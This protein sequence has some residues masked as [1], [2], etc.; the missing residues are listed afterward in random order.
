MSAV[1]RAIVLGAAAAILLAVLLEQAHALFFFLAAGLC[2][3]GDLL[4]RKMFRC[5]LDDSAICAA[6]PIDRTFDVT[7]TGN[8][9]RFFDYADY[10]MSFSYM[11]FYTSEG[12]FILPIPYIEASFNS[13]AVVQCHGLLRWTPVHIENNE[14]TPV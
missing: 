4:Y 11:V 7:L 14:V 12:R 3:L 9:G 5:L 10:D 8:R 1:I 2:L 6:I 13:V